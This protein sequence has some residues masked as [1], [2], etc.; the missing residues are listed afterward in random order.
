MQRRTGRS[1]ATSAMSVST[2]IEVRAR[3]DMVRMPGGRF[4]MGS[5]RFY[6]EEAPVRPAR[7][8]PFLIDETP[9]TNADFA[10]FVEATG[11]VT[12]AETAP[13]PAN[14][15]GILPDRLAPG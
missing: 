7:V 11:H 14:Y 15:P 10:R 9:V 12:L 13:D 2:S 5:D 3:P 8:G 1:R 4:R 6:P